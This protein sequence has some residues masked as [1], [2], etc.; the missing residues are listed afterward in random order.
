[1]KRSIMWTIYITAVFLVIAVP[2]L[3][4]EPGP[5]TMTGRVIGVDEGGKGIA[6]SAMSGGDEMV[7]GAI[8]D[9][10][11]QVQ[12]RGKKTDLTEIK[13]GDTVTMTYSYENNDLYAKKIS[14]K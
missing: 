1:M 11:T 13:T 10:S 8:V 12:V 14:K 9:E 3:A 7:A 4:T 5:R 2:A 6:I